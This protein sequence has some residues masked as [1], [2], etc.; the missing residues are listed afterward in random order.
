MLNIMQKPKILTVKLEHFEEPAV[1]LI[2]PEIVRKDLWRM[3]KGKPTTM[4]PSMLAYH[5]YDVLIRYQAPARK[6]RK[7]KPRYQRERGLL[8]M[9]ER[10]HHACGKKSGAVCPVLTFPVK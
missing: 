5:V 9:G 4:S 7:R 3:S 1:R 2:S 8:V 6:S 10:K